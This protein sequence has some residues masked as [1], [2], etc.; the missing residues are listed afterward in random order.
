MLAWLGLGLRLGHCTDVFLW[1]LGFFEM[2]LVTCCLVYAVH[3]AR[4]LASNIL[5]DAS[6]MLPSNV[7]A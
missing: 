1:L 2:F 3:V 7:Y 4:F 6:K 5:L